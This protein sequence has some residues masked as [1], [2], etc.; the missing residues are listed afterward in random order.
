MSDQD[1]QYSGY[2]SL[3]SELISGAIMD[4]SYREPPLVSFMLL[5]FNQEKFIEEA[6]RAALQQTYEPLEI[7]ISDDASTDQTYE[8]AKALVDQYDGPHRVVV[9]KN[10]NNMGINPHV[11]L[12]VKEAKG[13]FIVAAAG[14]DIS[15]PERTEKLVSH[16]Q[17]GASGVFSNALLIDAQGNSKGLFVRSGYKHMR[18]WRETALA[19]THGAWG[20]TFSWEKRVFDVFG[21]MQENILGEDAV[22]PFRC[23]ILKGISY[24]D[25]PLVQYRDHGQNVSFWAREKR[26]GTEEM[27]RLGSSIMQFKERMY[28]NWQQDLDLACNKGLVSEQERQWGRRV[29]IENTLLARRMDSLL[30]ANFI[31]LIVLLP[32]VGAYFAGRMIRLAPVYYSLKKTLL[33]LLNGVLHYR[34]PWLHQ[35]IHRLLGGY[36]K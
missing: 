25:E 12:A 6:V 3:E 16:W 11:N 22:I 17:S 10:A 27:V 31:G 15:L 2:S 4:Q 19:G 23:A 36:R 21:D 29:L 20:C 5:T 33:K 14:D 18:G 26:S 35:K 24:I 8:I 13:E 9:R 32:F 1:W 30:R 28:D 7:I 34:T